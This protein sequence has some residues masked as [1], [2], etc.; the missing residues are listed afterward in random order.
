MSPL[1]SV[2]PLEVC[3][4]RLHALSF[5]VLERPA[6][7][8]G[9]P[10]T[11]EL[12]AWAVDVYVFCLL[13][14]VRQLVESFTLLVRNAH[15]PTTFF[16]GRALFEVAGHARHVLG[17]LHAAL[18]ADDLDAAWALLSSATMGRDTRSRTVRECGRDWAPT[19]HVMD[20]VRGLAD[21]LPGTS[22]DER[23]RKAE[24]MY[25]HLCEFC[26]PN[27]A[28]FVQYGALEERGNRNYMRV[29]WSPDE[30]PPL[31]ETALAVIVALV[32]ASELLAIYDRHPELAGRVKA[33]REEL[34]AA[35]EGRR[36]R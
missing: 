21:V 17:K 5:P 33:A 14:H 15:W 10:R 18:H 11:H 12:I 30:R 27:M 9:E 26:H 24:D 13:A 34:M 35:R 23:E 32:A 25:A 1:E 16:V 20:D 4:T 36:R 29:L 28:A 8:R 7:R 31:N 22:R 19:I 3:A 6:G 2:A